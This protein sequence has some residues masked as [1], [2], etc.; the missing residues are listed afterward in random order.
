MSQLAGTDKHPAALMMP[1]EGWTTGQSEATNS[2]EPLFL[3]LGAPWRA[4]L[5]ELD[6]GALS[7]L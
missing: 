6:D 5:A 3:T 2:Q 4:L 7:G 1:T